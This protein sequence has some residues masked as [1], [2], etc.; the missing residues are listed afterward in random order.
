MPNIELHPARPIPAFR[1]IAIGTWATTFDPQVYGT[2]TVRMERALEFIEDFRKRTGKRV[3]VTHLVAKAVAL[4]FTRMP[5]ANAI[6]RFARIYP[7]KVIAV[8][9]QVAMTDPTTG[10][11]DL[12][13]TTI[14][15]VDR[16]SLAEIIDATEHN[17][18]LVRAD[19]DKALAKSRK[20]FSAVPGLILHRLLR[21]LSF[22]LY[23]LN[24]DLSWA[25][26]PKDGF[27]SVM[28]TNIGSL[29]LEVAYVPLVPWSRVPMIITVGKVNDEPV[30]E[31]GA[32][33]AGKVMRLSATFDHR[34][35]DGM[36][37][38]QLAKSIEE[39]F[40]E[41]ERLLEPP[42]TPQ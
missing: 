23:T 30:V 31:N 29:G 2:M 10:K 22:I 1:K 13:G 12:S 14:Y 20:T 15:N 18:K 11:P 4:A 9:L 28:V 24:I 8:F 17:V 16:M 34:F 3:T 37:A 33:V 36:H 42:I 21:F 6:L 41:P 35:I 5:D 7:R 27:G 38:A 40:R 25:G 19:Q 32:V 39:A 26:V